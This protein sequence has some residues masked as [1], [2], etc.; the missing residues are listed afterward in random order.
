MPPSIHDRKSAPQKSKM[1]RPRSAGST[2]CSTSM[3]DT[4]STGTPSDVWQPG[5]A[6][7]Y[8]TPCEHGR[9]QLGPGR[10]R[11]SVLPA[12]S[13]TRSAAQG[14]EEPAVARDH[15][16][17]R[18]PHAAAVPGQR[19]AR[20]RGR[21]RSRRAPLRRSRRRALGGVR[22]RGA[23]AARARHRR[24]LPARPG[25]MDPAE[26]SILRGASRLGYAARRRANRHG[27]RVPGSHGRGPAPPRSRSRS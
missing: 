16:A 7:C 17:D 15:G 1:R 26:A 8:V 11:S 12:A 13:P 24:R 9:R 23:A 18:G 2:R 5:A 27:L 25:V 20:R 14:R 3:R 19:R 4:V 22:R 21:A 6:H 10:S